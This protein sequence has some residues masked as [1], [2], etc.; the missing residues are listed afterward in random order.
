MLTNEIV[1]T[2]GESFI[3]SYY[4]CKVDE[5]I[6][7]IILSFKF[8]NGIEFTNRLFKN[9]DKIILNFYYWNSSNIWYYFCKYLFPDSLFKS[10]TVSVLFVEIICFTLPK[11]N[12]TGASTGAYWVKY[13]Q[14]YPLSFMYLRTF[15]EQWIEEL[16]II[17]KTQ[18]YCISI[19]SLI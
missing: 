14:L 5:T 3:S 15:A 18:S 6:D 11:S 13:M 2:S 7:Y 1:P 9:G 12:P 8:E 19:V 4:Q 10:I 17:N 16:S